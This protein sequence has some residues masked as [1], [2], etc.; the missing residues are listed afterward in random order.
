MPILSHN[1]GPQHNQSAAFNE[2]VSS[3]PMAMSMMVDSLVNMMQSNLPNTQHDKVDQLSIK[4]NIEQFVAQS[5]GEWRSM[6]SGH[7]LAFQQF[8]DVLSEITITQFDTD[9][10]EIKEAIKNSSQ[11]DD[12]TYIAPFRMEWNAESDWEPDDPTAV[13]SGSCI[14]IRSL[15]IKHQDIF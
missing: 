15:K 13:S 2:S 7:S 4:M 1:T 5:L 14:I 6:R 12:S 9:N 8:E 3:V 11:P 10:K